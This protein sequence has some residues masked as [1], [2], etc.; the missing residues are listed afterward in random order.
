MNIS[1]NTQREE[2]KQYIDTADDKKI[3]AFLLKSIIAGKLVKNSD[4]E[5]N[6]SIIF[7]KDGGLYALINSLVDSEEKK[8]IIT[9]DKFFKNIKYNDKSV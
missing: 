2:L 5:I 9:N 1:V 3:K 8:V 7:G 6:H 4:Y